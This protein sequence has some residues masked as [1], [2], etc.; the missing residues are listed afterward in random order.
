MKVALVQNQVSYQEFI[1]DYI[2]EKVKR[3]GVRSESF[4]ENVPL[5]L[6]Y[7]SSILKTHG[8]TPKIIDANAENLSKKETVERLK[9]FDPD[10][11][12]LM[13]ITFTANI[14]L[15]WI[16]YIKRKMDVKIVVGNYAMIH[17]PETILS[18]TSVDYGIIGSALDSLPKLLECI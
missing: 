2:P 7:V 3:G 6:M 8:H 11:V 10:M 17:Y 1:E 18:N 9:K 12:G 13:T 14:T 15:E 16:E 4:D 5:G